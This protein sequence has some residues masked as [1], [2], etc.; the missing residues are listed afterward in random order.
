[1]ARK[2]NTLQSQFDSIRAD[3]DM[4]RASR[5]VRKRKGVAPQGSGADYHYRTETQYYRDIEQARDMDRNDAVIGILADRRVDNIVQQ[6]FKLD[7]KTG[8]KGLDTEIW[9]RWME[10]SNDPDKCDIAG[11]CTWSEIERHCAR[12]ESIDGDIVVTGTDEGS[13]QVIEAHSIQT[14]TRTDDTFLGVTTNK[15]GKR[16]Q[17]H[18]LEET[19]K[20]GTK[21]DST[22]IDVR[23]ENG[24]RQVFHVYNP[25]RVL[26]TRGVTQIAPVFS[27]AGMLEDINFAKLVQQ[28]VVS[29]FAIFRKMASGGSNLP[30]QSSYGE[31]SVE[32][33]PGGTR[34]IEG[35]SPGMEIVGKPGEELQGFSP[36]VPNSEYFQQ[37]KLIMQILGVNFGLPLCLVLM[38]GS[39]TNF[40]GWRGAVDEARKGFV[41]DQLNLVRRLHK[42]A[43]EWWL[44][45][46]I[47]EDSEIAKWTDKPKLNIY[48][49]NWNLPTW[50]Y[51]EPVADAEG[52]ATQLRNSLT[53]PRRLHS[54]RG[55]DWEEVSEEIVD[56]NLYAITIAATKAAEFNVE[57][58]ASPPLNWR[59]LIP[60]VM[61]AG[62]TLALQDPAMVEAQAAATEKESVAAGA[63]MVGVRRSD[64][65]NLRKA[66]NDILQEMIA[67][68]ISEQRARMELDSLGITPQ[69]ID[70]YI[71]DALDGTIDT[72]EVLQD[73]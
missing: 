18:V 58:P 60:L 40:S 37:V 70:A 39:E 35:V 29:C 4:S 30:G 25:K 46:L 1:V 55:S 42:P 68:T 16:M 73:A 53:S 17:Y 71:A 6:G 32:S 54:A 67:K 44:S 47:V 26:Q 14:K 22:Q 62:Q 56:D 5:F 52:D 8:D 11:E 21:G 10:Y 65:K 69:K 61:P 36:N 34:Q 19:D 13:F 48:G 33:S 43:Y 45:R 12:A 38:D 57:N 7:P 50:S 3:Y 66:V 49:H 72:P 23:D 24:R 28:Q 9:N 31:S 27:Y 41:A 20:F 63:E 15:F 51:I 64:W 59:D 2:K